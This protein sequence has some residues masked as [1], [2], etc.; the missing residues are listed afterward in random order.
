[1]RMIAALPL[2]FLA[3]SAS[4]QFWTCPS[5]C[6]IADATR[7]PDLAQ[8][9]RTV[10]Q[11]VAWQSQFGA[12][13]SAL[14]QGIGGRGLLSTPA[15]A[16][17]PTSA[18]LPAAPS[19]LP[20]AAAR[21]VKQTLFVTAGA[22][23]TGSQLAELQLSRIGASATEGNAALAAAANHTALLPAVPGSGNGAMTA[24]AQAPSLRGDVSSAA[25]ARLVLLADLANAAR[26]LA[27]QAS[28]VH[29]SAA[30]RHYEVAASPDP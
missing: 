10:Q 18:D 27:L 15:I 19:L 30:L 8:A 1:M 7:L 9:A 29:S 24:A 21:V 28:L 6:P 2:L 16:P 5:P 25:A 26:L 12:A 4:A 22:A 13:G 20:L 23:F 14:G 3:S 11:M 17:M